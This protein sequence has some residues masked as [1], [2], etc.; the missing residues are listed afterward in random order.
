MAAYSSGSLEEA[1]K[2]A[3]RNIAAFSGDSRPILTSCASCFSHL[4]T[5]PE[6][7]AGD[8]EWHA[9]AENF[10]ARLREFSTFFANRIPEPAARKKI[11]A[12]EQKRIFYHDPCH[13]RFNHRILAAPRTLLAMVTQVKVVELEGGPQCCGQGGFFH[14][15]HPGIS[16]TIR[17][18]LL[19]SF[20]KTTAQEVVTTCSGCL[21]QWRHGLSRERVEHLALLLARFLARDTP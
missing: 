17:D 3:R 12:S 7:L 20:S 2:L 5:Y 10:A 11:P 1:K 21:L 19:D 18:N 8:E 9:A 16:R 14:L 6:L 13:L 15:I 4:S